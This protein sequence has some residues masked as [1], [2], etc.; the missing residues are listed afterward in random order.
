MKYYK[1]VYGYGEDD[2]HPITQEEL[3][4]AYV[5]AMEGGKAIFKSGFLQN[6]GKDFFRIEEDWHTTKGWVKNWKMTADDYFDVKPLESSYRKTME[7][8]RLLAEYIIKENKREL[9]ALPASQAFNEIREL[10]AG[11]KEIKN[12]TSPLA[13]KLTIN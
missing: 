1:I 2:Y 10:I 11:R 8:G 7:N 5:L 3:H 6:R 9:L 13:E 12:L 4:K